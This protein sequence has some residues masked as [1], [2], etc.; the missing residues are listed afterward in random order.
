VSDVLK[1]MSVKGAP[2]AESALARECIALLEREIS[3]KHIL[4]AFPLKIEPGRVY[5]NGLEFVSGALSKHLSGCHSVFVLA[6]TAGFA[7]D[8]LIMRYSGSDSAKAYCISACGS[9]AIE[10]YCDELCENLERGAKSRGESITLRF[11]PGYGDLSLS[12]QKKI[13]ALL[14][15]DKLL[16]ISL[17][18]KFIMTPSKSVTAII[19]V[20]KKK[21]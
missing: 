17:N 20:G 9:A 5:I 13:F 2:E 6:A 4:R 16:G 19:G 18:E 10:S 11:S 1:Y 7:P 3:P 12:E 21:V 14:N 8:R 15:C